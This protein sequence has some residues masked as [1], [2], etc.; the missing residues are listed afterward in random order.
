MT[1]RRRRLLERIVD[2]AVTVGAMAAVLVGLVWLWRLLE[3]AA[4]A[5]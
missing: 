4:G 2:G 3:L 1:P 5:L